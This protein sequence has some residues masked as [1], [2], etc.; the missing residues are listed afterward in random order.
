MAETAVSLALGEVFQLLREETNLLRGVNKD[1]LDIKDELEIIQVFL[2]DADRRASDEAD[3]NEGIRTWVKHMREASFR[4]EDVIDEYL[5]LRHEVK[6]PGCG[7]ICKIASLI[8]TL[9]PR[10]RIASEIQDIKISIREIKE[11][12]QRYNFQ[13][14]QALGSTSTRETENRRWR[15]PR[16]SFLFVEET[17]IV[18]LEGPREELTGWLLDGASERTVIAVVGMGGLGKTTLAKLVFDS[19]KVTTQF[20]CRACITVSQ[21]YTVRGLL[22]NMMEEFCGETEMSLMHMLHKMDDKLLIEQVR[23]YLE[24]KRYLIFFDDVWQED[25]SDQVELAMP[26]NNKGSRIIIT[27]RKMQAADF[28]KKSFLVHV[29]NLQLLT[30]NKAWELFCKKAFRFEHDGHCPAELKSIS[31]EIVRK[32]KQLP[33]AVVAIGGLFSTK[34]KTVTE[35]KTVS[36]NLN[37]E[38]RRNA[39][40]SNIIN[41]LSLSYDDLPYY[42]KPCI[43]YFSIYPEDYSI[44]HK[45]LIQQW[46]AEGF[47]KSDGRRT[48]EEVAEEYL[49]ELI[50]RSLVMMSS[51]GF[52]GKVTTCQVHDLLR[53]VIIGKMEDL[54]FCHF[55]DEVEKPLPVGKTRRLSISISSNNV[56]KGNKNSHFR[57]IHGFGKGGPMD[58][59]I[60]E[61]CSK[62]RILKVL[63]MQGTSMN[64]IPNNLGNLFHLR[65]INLS[66]TKVQTLPKS[67]GE[68]HNL[69]TLDLRETLV[70]EIPREINKLAKL[71]NL[72]ASH[73]NYEAMYSLL[74]FTTG[75]L[76][77]KG[78]KKLS[79]IENFF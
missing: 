6:H 47:V 27:T 9:T 53:E 35:W 43:L 68:L 67:V 41:I 17:G 48:L 29:H 70:H 46:I 23:K 61:L 2:K 15:D 19:Q 14:S 56:F 66:G 75:V 16:L 58:P 1:F 32:C 4:I 60:I 25:F 73:C 45:R 77:K 63:D 11:R 54:S 31:K 69:E 24:Y 52:E 59:F 13:R 79:S 40:L 76:M 42:L 44:N 72:L 18:G 26:N 57:A 10:H 62:S 20:H 30:P 37:L 7:L 39:H 28:F 38:L 5:W 8:K 22:I 36:K 78:I 51:V 65:Y 12:S 55:V 49:L 74:S 34:S 50:H 64:H 3:T 21:S 71:R 33:L